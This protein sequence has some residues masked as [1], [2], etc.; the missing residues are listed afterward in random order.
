MS[1]RPLSRARHYAPRA[2]ARTHSR[3][4]TTPTP[5]TTRRYAG[6]RACCETPRPQTGGCRR[7]FPVRRKVRDAAPRECLCTRPGGRGHF[8]HWE[9]HVWSSRRRRVCQCYTIRRRQ[10]L[11]NESRKKRGK[12][13]TVP[14]RPRPFVLAARARRAGTS[15]DS[16]A[17]RPTADLPAWRY[18]VYGLRT[19]SE[20]KK[21]NKTT[22]K[23]S[24]ATT[25]TGSLCLRPR[26]A[27][28]AR[29]AFDVRLCTMW[30]NDAH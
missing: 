11:E 1:F 15:A 24:F 20:K 4:T 16:P 8:S 9:S 29:R 10:W 17:C 2:F 19:V 22:R 7:R 30:V 14:K 12:K 27:T 6:A 5:A 3:P 18:F 28:W 26:A 13:P 25:T 23:Y 21:Q